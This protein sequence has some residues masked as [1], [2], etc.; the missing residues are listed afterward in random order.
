MVLCSYHE[1]TLFEGEQGGTFSLLASIRIG[2][3]AV[4]LW[5][6]GKIEVMIYSITKGD[7]GCEDL[8]G[9]ET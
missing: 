1:T 6:L 7:E 3:T 4:C 9:Q 5:K 2:N 8:I